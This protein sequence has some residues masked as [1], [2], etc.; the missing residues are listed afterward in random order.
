MASSLTIAQRIALN[1]AL[2]MPYATTY[3]TVGDIGTLSAQTSIGGTAAQANTELTTFLDTLTSSNGE[4]QLIALID[5]YIV[6]GTKVAN[7]DG[8]AVGGLQGVSMSYD[9]ERALIAK[10]IQVIVPFFKYHEIL[11]LR[12]S[13]GASGGMSIPIMR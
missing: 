6:I 13:Q 4:T 10:R 5:R 1:Q 2:E 7:I 12:A 8:G 11:A 3:Y 9:D